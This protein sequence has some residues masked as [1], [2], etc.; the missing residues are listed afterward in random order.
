MI[1]R[2]RQNGIE[3][4]ECQETFW[5][6]NEEREKISRGGWLHPIFWLH[7][8]KTYIRLIKK[9]LEV[10]K[11]DLMIVGYPGLIDIFPAR[12]LCWYKKKPLV[13]DIL[14]SLY[15]ISVERNPGSEKNLPTC[16]IRFVEYIASHLPDWLIIDTKVYADWFIENYRIPINKYFLL[17]LGADDRVFKPIESKN[18]QN[19]TFLC[20][21]YGTFVPSHGVSN[22]IE[23]ARLLNSNPGIHFQL[24]G[25]GPEKEGNVNLAKQYN[26]KNITFID[27]LDEE[28]LVTQIAKADVCLGTFGRS[29]QSL[30]TIQNKIYEGLAMAK[31]IITGKSPAIQLVLKNKEHIF[32]CERANPQAIVDA[33]LELWCNSEMRKKIAIQGYNLYRENFSLKITG[34]IL[35]NWLQ[36][37]YNDTQ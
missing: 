8:F 31:P 29:P 5:G 15:L 4:V 16:I 17:P 14:M 22:L 28:N 36:T 34:E 13:W 26:L 12:L 11:F 21:Y 37:I 20:I 35:A 25:N 9:F 23:A 27:W 10:Q 19:N 1:E 24:I 2:L 6:D 18:L 33:I 7:L 3:V 32:L 30:I